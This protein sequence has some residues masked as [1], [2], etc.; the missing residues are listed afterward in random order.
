MYNVPMKEF[1]QH[2]DEASVEALGALCG[3]RIQSILAPDCE[4]DARS[5]L[6]TVSSVS[7]PIGPARFI[8]LGNEWADTPQEWMHY[9]FLSVRIAPAPQCISYNPDPGPAGA[10]YKCDH[11]CVHLG[12]MERVEKI[13]VL[14]ATET[15]SKERVAYDA[16]LVLTRADSHQIAIVREQSIAARLQ[17]AHTRR[18]IARVTAG[19]NV[20]VEMKRNGDLPQGAQ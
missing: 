11:L 6:I 8:V 7:I 17:I 16:G 3:S 18:E 13:E 4:I 12:P 14:C 9:F 1:R 2:L 19:L 5:A 15:G 10:R 20:R